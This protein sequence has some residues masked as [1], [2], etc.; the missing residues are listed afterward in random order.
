MSEYVNI[1]LEEA[2]QK[3]LLFYANS[4]LN[5]EVGNAANSA[6][7]RAKILQAQPDCAQIQA[8]A[9]DQTKKAAAPVPTVSSPKVETKKLTAH[10]Q[11]DP[12]VKIKIFTDGTGLRPKDVHVG[13][14]GD[15]IIIQR[16]K[17]VSIP[18]RHYLALNDAIEDVARD[19]D[20]INPNTGLP[21][22]E[23]VSQHSYPFQVLAMPS[24]E[25]ITAWEKRTGSKA[26]S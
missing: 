20:E 8:K 3:Q 24:P 19:T 9:D 15:V 23:W 11:D 13:V 4:I 2:T 7:L 5:L 6:T 12:K 21:I 10:F 25:A 14:Q 1:P 16:E 26:L 17:E 22:K 18:Y